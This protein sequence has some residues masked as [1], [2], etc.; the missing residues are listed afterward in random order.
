[1]YKIIGDDGREYGPVDLLTLQDWV[2]EGRLTRATIV[3]DAD[4]GRQCPAGE[5]FALYDAFARASAPPPMVGPDVP[6]APPP[7]AAPI[8]ANRR[9]RV[10]SPSLA[11]LLSLCIIGFGQVYN[12]QALKGIAVLLATLALAE[13]M[14]VRGAIM[15]H[16]IAAVDAWAIAARI[17]RGENVGRWQWF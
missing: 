9:A 8:D 16:P 10:H 5:M 11:V 17:R 13:M 3:S 7:D 6:V 15:M 4:D 1:M 12:R 14:G 2:V